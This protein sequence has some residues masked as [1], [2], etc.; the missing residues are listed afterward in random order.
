MSPRSLLTTALAAALACLALGPAAAQA[1]APFD[2][3]LRG[4]ERAA[5]LGSGDERE[6]IRAE[7]DGSKLVLEEI[8]LCELEGAH[9]GQLHEGEAGGDCMESLVD[10]ELV[11]R[12]G[13]LRLRGVGLVCAGVRDRERLWVVGRRG[14]G[15]LRGVS[16]L[17]EI[18]VTKTVRST[19]ADE[20]K[21]VSVDAIDLD[22]IAVDGD[23]RARA[24]ETTLGCVI[25]EILVGQVHQLERDAAG[26][27]RPATT[28]QH[29]ERLGYVCATF[30]RIGWEACLALLDQH[31]ED[32]VRLALEGLDAETVCV[33]RLG[34]RDA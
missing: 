30:P 9:C 28:E 20:S 16:A 25:C 6:V 33:R 32:I 5:E 14:T 22:T 13:T 3:E 15:D 11:T 18:R 34:L 24:A 1:V 12:R 23:T 19:S 27:G 17:L 29:L 31:G 4:I 8:V 2:L 21:V 7:G 10:G 26:I